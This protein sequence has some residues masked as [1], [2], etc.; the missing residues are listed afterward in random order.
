MNNKLLLNKQCFWDLETSGAGKKEHP[1]SFESTPKWEQ[2]LQIAAIIVDENLQPTNQNLNEFCR[3][4]TSIIAQP[5][6]L[7]ATQKGIKDSL[8]AK[9]SSYELISIINNKF[10]EW[11]NQNN[12]LV[13]IGHNAIQ[14][15]STVLEYNLFNNL[16]FPYID[17]KSRGDTLN[18]SRAMY[19]LNPSSIKTPLTARGN[20]SFRL[21]QL[22]ELNNLPVEFAHDAYSDVK[23]SI[24]LTKFVYDSDPENWQQLSMTM[25]KE[26]AIE[27]I[28]K[29]KGFCYMTTFAGRIKL[30]AL[31]VVC[32]SSYSGW[33]NAFNL[34]YDPQPLLDANVEEF[35]KL[36][37]KKNRYVITNQ[38]PI[39][40]PGKLAVNYEPYNEIGS[41]ILNER[42]KIVFKNKSL[43]DKFKHMEID[44]Q[45]E[46]QDESSQDNIFPES[47]ANK[48][49]EF[50][51]QDIIKK[52]HEQK[53]W[54]EKYKIALTLR[55]P[56]AQFI[57]KRLIFDENPQTLSTEDFKMIHREMH[58]RL[59][60]NQERPFT[61][62][63]E[64]MTHIDT[65]F[66]KIEDGNEENKED[67]IT[68]LKDY[69]KYLLFLEKYF[70]NKNADPLPE[71]SK[72]SKHIFG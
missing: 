19:A 39:L 51:Q 41:D 45:L 56:R 31:S 50:R 64:A 43:A 47:K 60:I 11:K 3:P 58:D 25:N 69:N 30:E 66:S 72:L 12:N 6:A 1:K 57:A 68:I 28:N 34:A 71:G 29:N 49:M 61:T 55:D 33:Y 46:K 2:I 62:I 70:S 67:K 17:R 35:K 10:E 21:E 59:V 7:L 42:A 52:F 16:Y 63:P 54:D 14:F 48:F 40:L 22:A 4:R 15:D 36:I 27:F 26:N 8:N 23:T 18:L 9:Y 38:H 53:S 5:G 24:A 44:R 32:E 20:P 13:F 37:K 65:E